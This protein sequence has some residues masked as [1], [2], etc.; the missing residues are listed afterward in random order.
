MLQVCVTFAFSLWRF[1][2]RMILQRRDREGS[3]KR[4][5]RQNGFQSSICYLYEY[6]STREYRYAGFMISKHTDCVIEITFTEIL[7][8]D[9]SQL[10]FKF[11][12]WRAATSYPKH[13][14][15]CSSF[16]L[17]T[18]DSTS[19]SR[20]LCQFPL[21]ACQDTCRTLSLVLMPLERLGLQ[22]PS[23]QRQ[24]VA[25]LLVQIWPSQEPCR[26]HQCKQVAVDR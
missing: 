4:I 17:R 6:T 2:L 14:E 26:W 11:H 24:Q 15:H 19:L 21:L 10:R 3:R 7:C 8:V 25:P 12:T 9:A 1:R 22:V 23:W 16:R 13:L 20:W 5:L 18:A